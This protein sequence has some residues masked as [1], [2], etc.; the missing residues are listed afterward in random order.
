MAKYISTFITGFEE[1]IHK[2]IK[3]VLP[4]VKIIKI[5]NGLIFYEYKGNLDIQ[6]IF[7][8]NNTFE[9]IREFKNNTSFN[10]MV[11]KIIN[12]KNKIYSLRNN[13]N[14]N[15]TFRI[16]FSLNN[17]F[18][19]VR[20][21]IVKKIENYTVKNSCLKVNRLNPDIEFWF[22]K[23][24]D[25]Q[26]CCRLLTKRLSNE[27]ILMK[28]ELRSELAYLLVACAKINKDSVIWDPFAGYGSIPN[29]IIKHFVFKRTYI[30]DIS[31]QKINMLKTKKA[32][33]SRNV[34]INCCDIN[35]QKFIKEDKID[36]IITDPPWG[37]FD[38][39]D[40]IKKLYSNMLSSFHKVLSPTGSVFLLTARKNEFEEIIKY[41]P[42]K[43]EKRYN[44]LV[45]GKKASIYKIKLLIED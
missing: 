43:I 13:Y 24:T 30:S 23:R 26:I 15:Q 27:K 42:F 32:F 28:G 11:N 18:F 44:I 22:I 20:K 29:Q 10:D 38:K 7:F 5:Y 19:K 1:V 31:I 36:F 33:K 2:E 9:V 4:R 37:L 16:R 35:K 12:N 25:I 8:F 3:K 14:S 17:Q 40:D 34:V 45:N 6:K 39:I 21:D 41:S